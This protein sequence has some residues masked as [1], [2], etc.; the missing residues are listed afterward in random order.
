MDRRRWLTF[1]LAAVFML[2]IKEDLIPVLGGFGIYLVFQGERRR[3]TVLI[4][5]SAAALALVFGVI[6]TA[7]NDTGLYG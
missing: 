5:A 3:G 2:L 1:W 6:V 4:A 7:F